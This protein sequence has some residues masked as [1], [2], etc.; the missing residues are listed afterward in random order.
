MNETQSRLMRRNPLFELSHG[1]E[2]HRIE[3]G[4]QFRSIQCS[5]QRWRPFLLPI[6]LLYTVC[7]S[8]TSAFDMTTFSNYGVTRDFFGIGSKAGMMK[9]HKSKMSMSSLAQP[10]VRPR[11]QT[12]N[13][14]GK[15]PR[16]R[17]ASVP[18]AASDRTMRESA[19]LL[20]KKKP[21]GG[22]MLTRNTV[23]GALRKK[24][25][26]KSSEH[27]KLKGDTVNLQKYYDTELLTGKEEYTLGMKVRF[28]MECE[29][30]H[31]GI[32]A[33]LARI[34]T[35]DEWANACGFKKEYREENEFQ[36]LLNNDEKMLSSIRPARSSRFDSSVSPM[37]F[38]GN[39]LA[40]KSGV[41]RG[42]GRV[43]KEPPLFLTDFYDDSDEKFG[44][45][46]CEEP[47][48]RG[49]TTDFINIILEGRKAKSRMVE[50][51]MRLVV[52][53]ARRYSNIGVNV[54]DLVQEGSLGL[55]RA[56]EKFIP[57]KGFKFSTYASW[58]IQQAVFRSIAYHSRTIR[59]PVHVHNWLNK[60]R[61]IRLTLQNDLGRIPSS[62]EVALEMNMSVEKFDKMTELTKRTISLELPKYQNNP[63]DMGHSSDASLGDTIDS[64]QVK[65]E[66]TPE[67]KVDQGLFREEIKD[68]LQV[69]LICI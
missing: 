63:K 31:E 41:G 15:R 12:N 37:F 40:K 56:T 27:R 42:R 39:T 19:T 23:G 7:S 25:V 16:G 4:S 44:G 43:C 11:H 53:I 35:I 29:D 9:L 67:Q 61:K 32:T 1:K 20:A 38:V 54:Q 55:M 8:H 22:Q 36:V 24:K 64:T 5:G 49:T 30:V 52:S 18:G 66:V 45:S 60:V 21:R 10:L 50:C 28:L 34:P 48:N 3:Y 17:P 6:I 62:E 33:R 51:N 14:Y 26:H 59:L 46:A 57:S 68:M 13:D 47:I 69:S 65:G 2:E 58:W